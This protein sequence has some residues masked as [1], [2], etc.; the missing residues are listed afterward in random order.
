MSFIH[1]TQKIYNYPNA[2]YF[3]FSAL[4]SPFLLRD[5]ELIPSSP[6]EE[7][8]NISR[9]FQFRFKG[10]LAYEQ[11]VCSLCGQK[12]R[13]RS[14]KFFFHIQQDGNDVYLDVE[15]CCGFC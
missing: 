1:F 14:I 2:K 9:S 11:S 3:G 15:M 5:P 13:A 12:R 7:F 10:I 6:C 8:C 4:A